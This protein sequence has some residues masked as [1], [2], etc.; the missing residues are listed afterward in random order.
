M[1]LRLIDAKPHIVAITVTWLN[2]STMEFVLPG[3][4]CVSRRNRNDGRT[5]R[6]IA[7]YSRDGVDILC[8]I[9]N[10]TGS[11][12]SWDILRANA[13]PILFGV[14]YRQPDE[15][16]DGIV[17]FAAEFDSHFSDC[18]G[19]IILGDFN[20]HNMSSLKHSSHTSAS[21]IFLRRFCLIW[22]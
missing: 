21:G 3:Y 1:C 17:G 4:R 9:C 2:E 22:S 7:V 14:W 11:E 18:V 16:T 13:G 19:S 8:H 12:R 6:G 20:V 5:G 10:S 15:D